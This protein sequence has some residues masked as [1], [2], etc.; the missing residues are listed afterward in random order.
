MYIYICIYIYIR[1]IYMHV[2]IYV[3]IYMYV[4]INA[5]YACKHICIY[6]YIYVYIHIYTHNIHI[7]TH[8]FTTSKIVRKPTTIY[9]QVAWSLQA[10]FFRVHYCGVHCNTLQHTATPRNTPA[11]SFFGLFLGVYVYYC[12]SRPHEIFTC[13]EFQEGIRECYFLH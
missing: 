11:L 5:I 6:I 8:I 10:A 12:R 7:Y 13:T 4:Y 9:Q 2:N 3:Y 1:I